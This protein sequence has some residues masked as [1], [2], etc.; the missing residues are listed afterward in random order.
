MAYITTPD[1]GLELADPATIQ[2]F[3]TTNVNSNFLLLEAGIVADR[4]R[5]SAEE[6]KSAAIA[7]GAGRGNLAREVTSNPTTLSA[8]ADALIGDRALVFSPG[9]GIPPFWAECIGTPG[10][11]A[12]DWVPQDM[13][14]AATK[15]NL[16]AFIA[17]WIADTDLSFKVGALAYVTG[18]RM[19]YRFTT[20][21]GA[22]VFN[23]D[24][25]LPVSGASPLQATTG[26]AVQGADGVINLTNCTGNIDLCQIFNDTIARDF[27]VK[28][29]LIGSG[30]QNITMKMLD[31]LNAI[32][33]AKHSLIATGV[34]TNSTIG[35]ITA[36]AAASWGL[37][38]SATGVRHRY[39]LEFTDVTVAAETCVF[40][41]GADYT[42][43]VAVNTANAAG[44]KVF[45]HED[46]TI[47]RGLQLIISA[48]SVSGT[49]TVK[50]KIR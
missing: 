25:Q 27:D 43:P 11:N 50:S 30:A 6:T 36:P 40:V 10:S 3:E 47:M 26:T 20:Q 46:A 44:F 2:A 5:I 7:A 1:L 24:S 49:I 35:S 22:Y 38:M 21:A 29:D 13:I 42:N 12:A 48:G 23:S 9:T 45:V 14:V 19:M 16:D 32:A 41:K 15:A 39:T 34:G 37:T 8:I 33:T 17:A 28:L 4:V 18:T 31:A